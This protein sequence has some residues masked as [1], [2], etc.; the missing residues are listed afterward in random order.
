MLSKDIDT[1][2]LKICWLDSDAEDGLAIT[3]RERRLNAGFSSY[4]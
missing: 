3:E 2:M 1:P 4:W